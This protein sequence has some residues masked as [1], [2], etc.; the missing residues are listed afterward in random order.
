MEN[1]IKYSGLNALIGLILLIVFLV[2]IIGSLWGLWLGIEWLYNLIANG[3]KS[4]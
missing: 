2:G 3:L 4:A 1:E